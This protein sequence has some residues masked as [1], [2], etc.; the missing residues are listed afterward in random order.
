AINNR[1]DT[2]RVLLDQR[3][4]ID[5]QDDGGWT[6][7]SYGIYYGADLRLVGDLLEHGANP[8][9]LNTDGDNALSLAH[10]HDQPGISSLLL[11][12]G[13]AK[14]PPDPPPSVPPIARLLG[15]R[16]G[17]NGQD[18]LIHQFGAGVRTTGGHPGG[19]VSWL[20]RCPSA[21]VVTD[22]FNYNHE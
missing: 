17:F 16:I 1:S 15:V 22:G 3:V 4:D 8:N 11:Q 18:A 13:P 12:Y 7:L 20:T 21:H 6:A 10:E 9:L 2:V 5:A 19:C 14:N